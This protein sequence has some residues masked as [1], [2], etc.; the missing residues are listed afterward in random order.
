MFPLKKKKKNNV[1]QLHVRMYETVVSYISDCYAQKTVHREATRT[2]QDYRT[3]T[4]S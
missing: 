2:D 1:L 4:Y 3:L